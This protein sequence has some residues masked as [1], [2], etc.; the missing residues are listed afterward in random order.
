[1][2]TTVEKVSL[3]TV[4]SI[5]HTPDEF[6]PTPWTI[7]PTRLV[8]HAVPSLCVVGLNVDVNSITVLFSRTQHTRTA[9]LPL[10]AELEVKAGGAE[11]EYSPR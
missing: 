6:S 1:M 9:H 7:L 2:L 3:S 4:P 5:V 11:V 10:C 8:T